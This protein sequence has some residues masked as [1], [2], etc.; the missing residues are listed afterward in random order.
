MAVYA[1]LSTTMTMMLYRLGRAAVRRRRL[2]LAAWVLAAV[3]VLVLAQSGG[4][5]TIEAFKVPGVESQRALDV[6]E[7]R[8]PAQAGTSAQLVFA[9]K[10]GTLAD[11]AAAAAVDAALA[12]VRTQ[13]D[14]SKVGALQRSDDGRVAFANV[15]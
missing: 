4:G 1:R 6:L 9:A 5:K 11:P 7:E 8:F 15:Q 3:V 12:D 2:V 14:V 10:Q 13:R